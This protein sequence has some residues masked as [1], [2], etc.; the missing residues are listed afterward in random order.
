MAKANIPHKYGIANLKPHKMRRN[1]IHVFLAPP[2]LNRITVHVIHY[3]QLT[4]TE[5]T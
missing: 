3:L 1:L 5:Q 2:E 4:P